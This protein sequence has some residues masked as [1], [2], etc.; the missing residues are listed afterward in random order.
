MDNRTRRRRR[1]LAGYAVALA[2]L[3]VADDSVAEA[4]AYAAEAA[5][6][7]QRA[8]GLH[9]STKVREAAAAALEARRHDWMRIAR[10]RV[11]TARAETADTRQDLEMHAAASARLDAADEAE[12][13]WAAYAAEAASAMEEQRAQYRSAKTLCAAAAGETARCHQRVL[14]ARQQKVYAREESAQASYVLQLAVAAY[15]TMERAMPRDPN[16]FTTVQDYYSDEDEE[17]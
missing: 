7:S 5:A 14:L 10:R 3:H 15:A 17:E 2:G 13:L 12:A 4:A 8:R 16:A 11:V 1:K 6:A 9:R